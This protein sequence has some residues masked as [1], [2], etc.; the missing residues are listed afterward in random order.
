MQCL[1]IGLLY[2]F[3]RADL[4]VRCVLVTHTRGNFYSLGLHSDS[5]DLWRSSRGRYRIVW[6]AEYTALERNKNNFKA[7]ITSTLAEMS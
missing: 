4:S 6:S 7:K 1:V 3:N 2:S 5:H